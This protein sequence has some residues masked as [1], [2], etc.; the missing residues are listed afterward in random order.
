MNKY[1]E[2]FLKYLKIN[3]GYSDNT[4]LNY[5]VDINE[6]FDYLNDEKINFKSIDYQHIKPYLMKLHD[7][8]YKRATI[9]R[10]IS[11]LRSFYKY[12]SKESIIKDNPFLLVSVPKKDKKLPSFLYYNELDDLFNLPNMEESLGQRNRLIL[13]LLYATGVRVSELI[14]IK[15]KDINMSEK[16]IR[17][18]GKGNKMREVLYGDYCKDILNIYLNDGYLRLLKNEKSDYLILNNR[19]GS[20]TDRAIRYI[21]DDLIEQSALKKHISPHTL[22]HTFA[23]HL[24]ESGAD[25]LTVQELLGHESLSTTQIYTHITSERLRDIYLKAHPRAHEKQ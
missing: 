4:T 1:L 7:L 23:T 6:F 9:S 25:L 8:N 20:I 2:S 10:K 15:L 5:E 21:I 19:G 22:R 13:E 17:V 18:I 16:S 24:L 11:S 12:L 3:R 14:H